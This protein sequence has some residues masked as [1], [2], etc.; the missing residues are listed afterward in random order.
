MR[1]PFAEEPESFEESGPTAY[2]FLH[3]L[4]YYA[5]LVALSLVA[6]FGTRR[7]LFHDVGSASEL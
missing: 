5:F 1:V 3:G 2:V 4:L 7:D 6:L